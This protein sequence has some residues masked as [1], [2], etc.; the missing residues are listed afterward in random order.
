[1]NPIKK[2]IQLLTLSCLT[3]TSVPLFSQEL[4]VNISRDIASIEVMHHG[5]MVTIQR[6]QD[7]KNKISD[8]YALTSRPCPRF[9]IQPIKIAQGVETVGE[10]EVISYL[11]QIQ[12]GNSAL[13]LIDSRTPDWVKRGTIPGSINIPWTTLN[14]DSGADSISI[15]EILENQFKAIETEQG[16]DFSTAKTLIL[17]CNGMW[18]GQSANSIKALL[19]LGYPSTKLKWYRDGMQTWEALGLT[20]IK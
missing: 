18:C 12:K 20:T 8:H 3:F 16:W 15:D 6:N 11:Q 13:L 1:M 9:C 5:K 19:E 14:T 7:T 17:F 10:L 2:L 4:V